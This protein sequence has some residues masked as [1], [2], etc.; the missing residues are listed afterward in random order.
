MAATDLSD[1]VDAPRETLEIEIKSWLDFNDGV[2][3]AKLARHAAAL[4][5]HG[6]GYIVFG[7]KDDLSV[8][9]ARPASLAIY[10]R[11]TFTGIFK[12]YL[13][14]LFQCE[15]VLVEDKSGQAFPV[16]RIPSHG[17]TPIVAKADGPNDNS[18]RPQG[19]QAGFCYIRKPGPESARAVSDECFLEALGRAPGFQWPVSLADN[20]YQLS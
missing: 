1:L 12:K 8:D 20:R 11:D 17:R 19:I 14:P 3:R 13:S 5:N 6:G 10:N 9:P 4:A 16:V 15:V 18:G 7:F 2:V